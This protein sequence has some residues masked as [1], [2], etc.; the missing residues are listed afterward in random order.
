MSFVRISLQN[1]THN[2]I[3]HHLSRNNSHV[4][5]RPVSLGENESSL[6]VSSDSTKKLKD[7]LQEFH[8]DGILAKYNPEEVRSELTTKKEAYPPMHER[9]CS[10]QSQN[11]ELSSSRSDAHRVFFLFSCSRLQKQEILNQ[12]TALFFFAGL[13]LRLKYS[14]I[15]YISKHNIE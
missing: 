7:V 4:A 3:F 9:L 8:G 11:R 1:L 6:T 15:H 10:K 5:C 12:V 13:T 14:Q 2:Q